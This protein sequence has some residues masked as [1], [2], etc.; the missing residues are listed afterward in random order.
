MDLQKT[1][2]FLLLIAGTLFLSGCNQALPF[3]EFSPETSSALFKFSAASGTPFS[4][5]AKKAVLT[6]SA[7][8]MNTITR[9]LKIISTGI[10][11]TVTGIPSGKNRLFAIAVYD[12]L[13]T[14][15]YSGS[16]AADLPKGSTVNVPLTIKRVS[17]NAVVD[18]QII[19]NKSD[20]LEKGLVAWYPLNGSAHDMSGNFNDGAIYGAIP[21]TDRA[22]RANSA[23]LFDGVNDYIE[24][25]Y[26][27]TIDCEDSISIVVWA[28]S[29][30]PGTQYT[31]IGT[32]LQ[33]GIGTQEAYAIIVD[34]ATDV[35]EC[36]YRY[37][38]TQPIPVN[39][40]ITR[41]AYDSSI[42]DGGVR[43][44]DMLDTSWHCYAFTFNGDSMSVYVD[45]TFI[46]SKTAIPG[47]IS[48]LP[49]RIGAQSKALGEYWRGKIDALR[50]YRRT[51]TKEEIEALLLLSD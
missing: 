29:D 33:M 9:T 17:T 21:S 40:V 15:Q 12:S 47:T 46:G 18:V 10:E 13:D 30:I 50:I 7:P 39:G 27:S 4:R 41:A 2:W 20:S 49:L 22:G 43:A 32:I 28:K 24:I 31:G 8:D 48:N 3:D 16:T 51:L 26:D 11:D 6:I 23:Y 45:A 14:L 44:I 5:L 35:I 1:F 34:Y 42:I 36:Y 19:E 37:H 25:P 38:W